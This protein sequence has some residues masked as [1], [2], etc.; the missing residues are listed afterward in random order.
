MSLLTF[1]QV[2]QVAQHYHLGCRVGSALS[3]ELCFTPELESIGG[4]TGVTIDG[5]PIPHEY[6]TH[7]QEVFLYVMKVQAQRAIDTLRPLSELVINRA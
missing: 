1:S 3:L 5:V 4:N 6:H 2:F 7:L